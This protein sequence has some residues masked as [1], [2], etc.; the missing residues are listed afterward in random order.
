ME[1]KAHA[2]AAGAFVLVVTALLI[3]LA[4][5]LMRDKEVFR[6][7]EISTREGLSGLQVQAPVR[8]RGISVGK[9]AYIGFDPQVKGNALLRIAVDENAPITQS[10]YA[11]LGFQGITGLGYVQLDDNGKSTQPIPRVEDGGYPRIPLR[12]NLLSS[13]SD[14]GTKMLREVEETT[15]RVNLLFAPD[16]QK[17]LI[18]AVKQLGQAA[19]SVNRLAASVDTTLTQRLDPALAAVPPLADATRKTLQSLQGASDEFGQVARRANQKGGV[20]DQLTDASHALTQAAATL[21]AGALPSVSRAGDDV[22]RTAR[23]VTRTVR[24]ISDNPQ[25]LVFG[26]GAVQPG[27]GEAGFVAPAATK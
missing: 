16:N 6:V 3:A 14:E 21:N 2:M 8:Y 23:Q 13:L 22:A 9:V 27:P 11:T 10:T 24:A 19:D 25:S 18:D 1:N 26:S 7:Y 4:A 5:W 15:Q 20:M 17:A 12:P